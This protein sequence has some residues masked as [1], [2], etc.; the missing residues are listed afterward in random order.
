MVNGVA[1]IFHYDI[2]GNLIAESSLNGIITKEYIYLDSQPL[3]MI[4]STNGESIFFYHNDHLGTPKV[5][6]DLP[7]NVVWKANHAPFGKA[8][9]II[10]TIENNLRFPGQY[11]DGETGLHYNWHRYYDPT[12]G[13]YLTPD[14]IGLA[15]GINPFVYSYNNPVNF[16]DPL[17]LFWFRQDWQKKGVVG[18]RDTI[19]PPGGL[20]SESMEKFQPGG[21][22]F[23]EIHD[24][25][26]EL[27]RDGL[28]IPDSIVNYPSMIPMM[29]IA[30]WIEFLRSQGVLDQP[31]PQ[32]K[33]EPCK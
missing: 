5:M 14:P 9:I 10:N 23:G 24:F 18:R 6:T 11:Y 22:T 32:V 20:I 2:F 13:R 8:E 16:T 26:V 19:V 28:G 7:G 4:T 30:F 1:V 12:T 3:A 15:G 25:F 17:G 33:E 27:T 21:Y 31:T 29:H